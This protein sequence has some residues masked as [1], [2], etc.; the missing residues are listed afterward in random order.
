MDDKASRNVSA[1]RPP[2]KRHRHVCGN[3][4]RHHAH[5]RDGLPRAA[6]KQPAAVRTVL[7]RLLPLFTDEKFLTDVKYAGTMKAVVGATKSRT[8]TRARP[9]C[10]VWEHSPK[11]LRPTCSTSTHFIVFTSNATDRSEQSALLKPAYRQLAPSV[12]RAVVAYRKR[13]IHRNHMCLRHT[14]SI[15]LENT[16]SLA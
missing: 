13:R 7:A 4:R 5:G 1:R 16:H 3:G 14:R 6:V 9:F 12:S 2:S 10:F 15:Q 8:K 11:L